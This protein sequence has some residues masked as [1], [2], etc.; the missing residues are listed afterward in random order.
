MYYTETCLQV[1]PR[2][3]YISDDSL[4]QVL[5][6]NLSVTSLSPH[7]PSI[8]TA[9]HSL[10]THSPGKEGDPVVITAVASVEGEQL[11]LTEPVSPSSSC[12]HM[13]ALSLSLS[14]I[15]DLTPKGREACHLCLLG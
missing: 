1:F 3:C 12:I 11:C 10:L 14:L 2:F 6:D 13:R 7:L 8:F 4:L 15:S 9:L 5:S